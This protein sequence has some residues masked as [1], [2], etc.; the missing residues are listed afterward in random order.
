M[1]SSGCRLS[2]APVVLLNTAVTFA[3]LCTTRTAGEWGEGC[4]AMLSGVF[5]PYAGMP[6]TPLQPLR[7]DLTA[8][9]VTSRLEPDAQAELAWVC[10]ST[11]PLN[12]PAFSHVITLTNLQV[13]F[14]CVTWGFVVLRLRQLV[15]GRSI[16][17]W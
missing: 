17:G 10:T 5:H 12:A 13:S 11:T 15:F 6:P 1:L 14:E 4:G 7:V 3:L 8:S 16:G 2:Q 9:P